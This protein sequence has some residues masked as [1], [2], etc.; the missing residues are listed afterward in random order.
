M[1]I[2]GPGNLS[3]IRK[4]AARRQA[5]AGGTAPLNGAGAVDDVE[6]SVVAQLLSELEQLPPIRRERVEQIRAE[7]RDGTYETEEKLADAVDRLILELLGLD[8]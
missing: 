6:L 2:Q 8:A 4:V 1:E 3:R 5:G 7:I